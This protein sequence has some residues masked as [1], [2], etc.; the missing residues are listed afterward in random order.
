MPQSPVRYKNVKHGRNPTHQLH[1]FMGL[2]CALTKCSLN[3]RYIGLIAQSMSHSK[4][5]TPVS[6]INIQ[7]YPFYR[8]RG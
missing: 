2:L 6:D 4:L 1:G 5:I 7:K 8:L 3:D